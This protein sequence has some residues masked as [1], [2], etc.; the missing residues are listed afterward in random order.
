MT[1]DKAKEENPIVAVITEIRINQDKTQCPV[2]I[3]NDFGLFMDLIL[4]DL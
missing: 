4:K 1:E 2:P 3:P